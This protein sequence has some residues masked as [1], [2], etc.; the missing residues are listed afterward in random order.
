MTKKKSTTPD[1]PGARL[2]TGYPVQASNLTIEIWAEGDVKDRR[3]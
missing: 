1:D 3:L 2:R